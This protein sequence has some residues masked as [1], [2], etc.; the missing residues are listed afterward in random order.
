MGR[1]TGGNSESLE[2]TPDSDSRHGSVTRDAGE[3]EAGLSNC[4]ANGRA[5]KARSLFERYGQGCVRF[6]SLEDLALDVV[7]RTVARVSAEEHMANYQ[8]A[9]ASAEDDVLS[10]AGRDRPCDEDLTRRHQDERTRASSA[11]DYAET[12]G[13]RPV[14]SAFPATS[15]RRPRHAH[16]IRVVG[17]CH[18]ATR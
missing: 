5:W 6:K 10:S 7:G 4:G 1:R 11:H 3:D 16:S 17:G 13:K 8:A 2:R 15:P 9:R 14:H 12:P 18:A